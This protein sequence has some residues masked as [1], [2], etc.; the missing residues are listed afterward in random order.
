M[1]GPTFTTNF[2]Y[3]KSFGF[4]LPST[5]IIVGIQATVNVTQ[6]GDPDTVD[7]GVFLLKAGTPVGSDHSGAGSLG[8]NYGSGTDLWGASWLYSDI[9]DPGFGIAFSA[10]DNDGATF[11]T[12]NVNSVTI[13]I[14]YSLG[15]SG[16][17][18][19]YLIAQGFNLNIPTGAT[20]VGIQ[21]N[22][23]AF[24]ELDSGALSDNHIFLCHGSGPS[25]FGTD[26]AGSIA[27]GAGLALSLVGSS[28]DTWGVAPT[29]AMLN[30]PTFGIAISVANSGAPAEAAIDA[31]Y[32]TVTYTGG[33]GSGPT[34]SSSQMIFYLQDPDPGATLPEVAGLGIVAAL[35]G[36]DLLDGNYNYYVSSMDGRQNSSAGVLA[37]TSIS[38]GGGAGKITLT[39]NVVS[40]AGSYLIWRSYNGAAYAPYDQVFQ[41]PFQQPVLGTTVTYIDPGTPS[42]GLVN[43]PYGT[44]ILGTNSTIG[45]LR[46]FKCLGINPVSLQF[47]NPVQ[48]ASFP[49]R[50]NDAAI[51]SIPPVSA[52][53]GLA[54]ASGQVPDLIQFSGFMVIALGNGFPIHYTDG[55]TVKPLTSTFTAQYVNW[56][57]ATTYLVG[58][59]VTATVA[60]T[61][62]VFTCQQQGQTQTPG[63]PAW[64]ATLNNTVID[65]QVLWINSGP[66]T[67]S[68]PPPGGAHIAY[69][70][71]ALWVLNNSPINTADGLH[72]QSSLRMSD[73]DDITSWN[74]L[75]VA[76]IG[77]DDG[78]DGMGLASFTIAELGIAPL[79]SLIVFKDFTTYQIVGVFGAQD[80]SIQQLQT[81]MGCI[82]PRSIRFLSGYG[83][84]RMTHLGI[85]LLDGVRDRLISE[86]IRPFI[87]G[88]P[89]VQGKGVQPIIPIDIN[90]AYLCKADQVSLPPMYAIAAPLKGN[91]SLNRLFL[92]D[93]VLRS[94]VIIDL[95]ASINP[96]SYISSI[97][98]TRGQE[99]EPLTLIGGYDN[100]SIQVIQ[101]GSQ[102]W[103]LAASAAA[104]QWAFTTPEVYNQQDMTAP[105]R[106]GQ[107]YIKGVNLDSNPIAVT[108]NLQTEAGWI[109]DKR[110]YAIG[111][112]DFELTVG[113]NEDV[114]SA[115]AIISGTG[116]VEIDGCMWDVAPLPGMVPYR[117]T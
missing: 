106:A 110:V 73:V 23:Y 34:V 69:H 25:T 43:Y 94:W 41:P 58:D 93:L 63:P 84:A 27:W 1:P 101:N 38:G 17:Y 46:L 77:K 32:I 53:G 62:Y 86:P 4:A 78:S 11:S 88:T 108:I 55:T 59:Q 111:A 24:D 31:I 51:P 26:H 117:I 64:T 75:N 65:G 103:Q 115:N 44:T 8:G 82:A 21:F 112:G 105:I 47:Q 33:A 95:P 35:S 12:V 61:P 49:C 29:P 91:V 16:G 57:A 6:I 107:L 96:T 80:F 71:G 76:F 74:P 66:V 98:Q 15:S 48:I 56:Q 5:A 67:T 30:D 97:S 50:A 10:V 45:A 40:G 19:D 85:A 54:G 81:D 104:V 22:I 114:L 89:A 70:S 109:A 68:P 72:G 100:G 83:I 36:G 116:R 2:L 20:I 90:H 28:S 7:A 13:T 99:F 92:Y 60:G 113:I 102:L 42:P 9:N 79:G 52:S 37:A 87:F 18:S 3:V 14:F 39:W